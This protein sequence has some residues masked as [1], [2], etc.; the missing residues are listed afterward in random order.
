MNFTG[1]FIHDLYI[2]NVY[3]NLPSKDPLEI[4][5]CFKSI[6]VEEYTMHLFK[7]NIIEYDIVDDK[8]LVKL[9]Y[10]KE[11]QKK[12]KVLKKIN[13]LNIIDYNNGEESYLIYESKIVKN[14]LFLTKQKYDLY[15][16]Y[17][18]DLNEEDKYKLLAYITI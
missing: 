12:E 7:P 16:I 6:K 1:K 5:S 9:F 15:H 8:K 11:N 18:L 10:Q 17:K 3:N 4:A 13:L 14:L 2:K